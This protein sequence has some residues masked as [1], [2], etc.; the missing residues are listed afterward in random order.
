MIESLTKEQEGLMEVYKKKWVDIGLSTVPFTTEEAKV[1]MEDFYK[2]ILN[3][4]FPPDFIVVDSPMEAWKKVCELKLLPGEDTSFIFPYLD[5]HLSAGFFSMYDYMKE[6]VGVTG[7]TN[8]WEVY[9]NTTKLGITYTFDDLCIVSRKPVSI[10]MAKEVLHNTEGPSVR[11]A[12]GFEIYSL[13]GIKV[14]KE[15]VMTP[16]EMLNVDMI[17]KEKNAERRREIIR[18]IGIERVLEKL[19]AAIV[20]EWNGYTLLDMPNIEGMVSK[21]KWIKMQNPSLPGVYHI[22]G[23]PY[24]MK[25]CQEALAWRCHGVK[26]EPSQLT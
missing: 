6:V 22:E 24:E 10:S 12:D 15:I 16:A 9:F 3:I 17:L 21:A 23:V 13:N 5:G 18:K 25:T 11:Y 20:D 2:H 1:I 8:L 26:W 4:P 7:Y 14:T 19:H